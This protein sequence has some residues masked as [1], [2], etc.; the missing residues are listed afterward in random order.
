[1]PKAL[2]YLTKA[3][4]EEA[5]LYGQFD[6]RVSQLRIALV[7]HWED[8]A[9]YSKALNLIETQLNLHSKNNVK[10]D[11]FVWLMSSKAN[12]SRLQGN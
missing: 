11:D 5:R 2:E 6:E 4:V 9:E 10:G 1:M 12:I 7:E 3:I 8:E